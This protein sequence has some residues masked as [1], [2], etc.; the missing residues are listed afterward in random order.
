MLFSLTSCATTMQSSPE[1]L[2]KLQANEGIVTGSVQIKGGKDLI[3]RTKW[4]LAVIPVDGKRSEYQLEAHRDGKEELFT[5]KMIAGKYLISKVY[6]DGFSTFVSYVNI[7]FSVEPGVTKYIGK[8][9]IEF[10]E[11]YIKMGT[12][13]TISIEDDKT[14][15]LSNTEQLAGIS[16]RNI[17]T[18]LMTSQYKT[19]CLTG[20]LS[21]AGAPVTVTVTP[22]CQ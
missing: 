1:D 14:S 7:Q 10:P 5:A 19:S 20:P 18:D 9:L 17:V 16:P 3:G 8:L 4:K 12:K 22:D 21:F 13:Y 2:K 6:Q 11:E 15:F